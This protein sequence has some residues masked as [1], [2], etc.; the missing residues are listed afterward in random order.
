[1]GGRHKNVE[2]PMINAQDIRKTKYQHLK[3]LLVFWNA[4][5]DKFESCHMLMAEPWTY[6]NFEFILFETS[7]KTCHMLTAEPSSHLFFFKMQTYNMLTAQPSTYD[8]FVLIELFGRK[9][10]SVNYEKNW[11]VTLLGLSDVGL[12]C[13]RFFNMSVC[14]N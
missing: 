11:S 9:V 7:R 5:Y 8:M 6:N 1:M 10:Q 3:L 2:D 4:L 14:T 12:L 13:W